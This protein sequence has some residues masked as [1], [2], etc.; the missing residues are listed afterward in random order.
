[1]ASFPSSSVN[2]NHIKPHLSSLNYFQGSP[3]RQY[4]SG[5][6][7]AIKMSFRGFVIPMMRR[8]GIPAAKSFLRAAAPEVI[9]VLDGTSKPKAAVKNALKKTIRQQVGGGLKRFEIRKKGRVASR[10]K[11]KSIGVR[12]VRKS[13][14]KRKKSFKKNRSR[15]TVARKKKTP[16]QRKTFK[17][18][19]SCKKSNKKKR[20][21]QDFFASIVD[22]V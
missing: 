21:R 22:R 20:S 12:K 18:S 4:G 16:S 13:K 15:K 6:G 2:S 8:Y 14:S 1:M 19:S 5:L 7:T 10:K 9:N 3:S 11:N 17:P